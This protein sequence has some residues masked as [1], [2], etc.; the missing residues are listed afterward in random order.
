MPLTASAWPRTSD[1]SAMHLW[2]QQLYKLITIKVF[3]QRRNLFNCSPLKSQGTHMS[4]FIWP[5]GFSTVCQLKVC[6]RLTEKIN[7]WLER[8]K[9]L[10][11][12]KSTMLRREGQAKLIGLRKQSFIQNGCPMVTQL[13]CNL[14]PLRFNTLTY[15]LIIH[16]LCWKSKRIC[17][18]C[19]I[20]GMKPRNYD[21]NL[22]QN[23]IWERRV[24]NTFCH[25]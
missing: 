12:L 15:F 10:L 21:I 24:I 6:G 22:S 7:S 16:L 8:R 11:W 25:L 9:V 23:N 13:S 17:I 19:K 2:Q 5:L 20:D 4:I 14:I 1:G 3:Q 18:F